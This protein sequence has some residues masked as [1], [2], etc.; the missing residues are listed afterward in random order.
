MFEVKGQTVQT[1]G[2]EWPPTYFFN[3]HCG[4]VQSW[5]GWRGWTKDCAMRAVDQSIE[6]NATVLATRASKVTV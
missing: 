2:A 1:Q 6:G 5:F 4:K 3:V